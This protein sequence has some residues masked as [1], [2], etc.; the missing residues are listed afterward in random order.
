MIDIN[1]NPNI[2]NGCLAINARYLTANVLVSAAPRNF[3]AGNTAIA[4]EGGIRSV[5]VRLT[6]AGDHYMML[7]RL[8]K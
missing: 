3:L 5:S 6:S 7:S 2:K 4:G 8:E 1:G